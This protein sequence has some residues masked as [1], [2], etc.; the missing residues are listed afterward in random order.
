MLDSLFSS[1]QKGGAGTPDRAMRLGLATGIFISPK[2]VFRSGP[3]CITRTVGATGTSEI[4][5]F[6]AINCVSKLRIRLV[7]KAPALGT[8]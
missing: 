7:L 4:A 6:K 1:N 8:Q 3:Y 5:V 2:R